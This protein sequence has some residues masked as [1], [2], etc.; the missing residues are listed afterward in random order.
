M[1][2]SNYF[3]VDCRQVKSF[4]ISWPPP[5]ILSFLSFLLQ[6]LVVI[7]VHRV[8]TNTN[9][10]PSFT[11]ITLKN[12][13]GGGIQNLHSIVYLLACLTVCRNFLYSF[14]F[15]ICIL[16]SVSVLCKGNQF[17]QAFQL[18]VRKSGESEKPALTCHW[19]ASFISHH[20]RCRCC[21]QGAHKTKLNKATSR[22]V[23]GQ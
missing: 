21:G 1:V 16:L 6:S 14:F 2:N 22:L 23:S 10:G 3:Y 7:H 11:K 8:Q 20:K 13:F 19:G 18:G 12:D 4:R 9:F 17:F 15:S 5:P